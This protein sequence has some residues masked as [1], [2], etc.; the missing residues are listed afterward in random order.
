MEDGGSRTKFT[1]CSKVQQFAKQIQNP[2]MVQDLLDKC[3]TKLTEVAIIV[4]VCAVE[5][6]LVQEDK[7][8]TYTHDVFYSC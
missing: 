8:A 3:R 5:A 6:T 1:D 7:P 4:I 2:G